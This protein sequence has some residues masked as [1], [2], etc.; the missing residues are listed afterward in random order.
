MGAISRARLRAQREAIYRFFAGGTEVQ[1]LDS[2]SPNRVRFPEVGE[3]F[4]QEHRPD[5]KG[6]VRGSGVELEEVKASGRALDRAE[7]RVPYASN[8]RKRQKQRQ[9]ARVGR[10]R[11]ASFARQYGTGAV[12]SQR[13]EGSEPYAYIQSDNP[14]PVCFNNSLGGKMMYE[15]EAVVIHHQRWKKGTSTS[16]RRLREDMMLRK[17]LAR[18]PGPA[19]G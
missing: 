12:I 3:G 16:S 9:M 1:R 10:N 14:S 17:G 18:R 7:R 4:P 2:G 11:T 6:L 5:E 8:K 19:I 13:Q 15:G